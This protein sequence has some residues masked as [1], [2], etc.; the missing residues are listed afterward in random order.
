M[1]S[2]S[3]FTDPND[4]ELPLPPNTIEP[5]SIL[6]FAPMNQTYSQ[7]GTPMLLA[8]FWDGN[9]IIYQTQPGV[10]ETIQSQVM[11]QNNAQ[12]PILGLAWCID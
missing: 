3:T 4:S 12:A 7:F 8:A 10:N 9:L 6:K 5:V 2:T 1:M 11:L